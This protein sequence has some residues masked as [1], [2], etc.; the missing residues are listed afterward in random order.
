MQLLNYLL[1]INLYIWESFLL[2]HLGIGA[3]IALSASGRNEEDV[4][5]I[6]LQGMAAGTLLYVVF[7]EVLARE[8]NNRHS[9]IW[10][11]IAITAGFAVMFALQLAS[12]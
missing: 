9:G 3:G 2:L 6:I 7:F 12:E 5:S 1:C 10:Q 4:T 8:K 11:L